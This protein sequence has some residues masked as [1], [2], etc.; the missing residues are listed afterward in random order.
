MV[1][2]CDNEIE[3]NCEI[4]CDDDCDGV[5]ERLTLCEKDPTCDALVVIVSLIDEVCDWL[6]LALCDWVDDEL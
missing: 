2:V 3:L 1:C 6:E 4:V 5:E